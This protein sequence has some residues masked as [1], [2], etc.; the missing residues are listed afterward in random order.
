MELDLVIHGVLWPTVLALG[1]LV[2]SRSQRSRLVGVA[3]A[4]AFVVSSGAQD[5][6][7]LTPGVGSWTWIPIGVAFAALVGAAAGEHGAG[8]VGRAACCVI[9]ALL[10]ALLMPL[11]EWRDD[12]ERLLLAGAIALNAALLLPIGMHRGGFSTWLA[13]S[14]AL[15]GTSGVALITGFAKLAI[16]CGAISFA[17]GC[18]GLFA[19]G[20]RPHRSLHAGIGGAIVIAVCASLG[21]AGAYAFETGGVPK[22]VFVLAAVAPLGVWL[23]E[24]PPFRATRV[25]SALARVA[26]VGALAG[27]AVWAAASHGAQGSDAY[28]AH[29]DWN[30]KQVVA[31]LA[32]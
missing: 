4:L 21:A 1:V 3:L 27:A 25:A 12:D 15:A 9:A 2:A 11:P 6:L 5:H 23:G 28:A 17:C 29:G 7:T 14:V 22:A 20:R 31:N 30:A 10:A 32:R 26:G 19:L 18:M 16:P 24:A 13:F 8:R